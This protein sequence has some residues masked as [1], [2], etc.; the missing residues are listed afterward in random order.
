M[1]LSTY[2]NNVQLVITYTVPGLGTLTKSLH[3]VINYSTT[4]T[5]SPS[6]FLLGSFLTKWVA[7]VQTALRACLD[8]STI[9]AEYAVYDLNS[10][11]LA[12]YVTLPNLTGSYNA[13]PGAP[14]PSHINAFAYLKTGHRG[15]GSWGGLHL[16]GLPKA[17]LTG[18][19]FD[20]TYQTL[21]DTLLPLIVG[22]MTDAQGNIWKAV[23]LSRK[24]SSLVP[25]GPPV[26]VQADAVY[27]S[28]SAW[29]D[30]VKSLKRRSI[31]LVRA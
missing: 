3:N 9:V 23:I 21:L 18:N 26:N 27:A 15:K 28:F 4:T 10:P 6:F 25:P 24:K 14:A 30:Q 1:P 31:G 8:F 11:T 19:L 12:P 2:G 17:G 22:P 29:D 20:S 13:S 7:D 16:G 5:P